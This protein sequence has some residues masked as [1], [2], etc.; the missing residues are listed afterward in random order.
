MAITATD[1]ITAI[2]DTQ[3]TRARGRNLSAYTRDKAKATAAI[4]DDIATGRYRSK[5]CYKEKDI[6]NVNGKRRHI[7]CPD[8]YT[9]ILE[10]LATGLLS[11]IYAR[12][13]PMVGVNCKKGCGISAKWR[14][15]SVAKRVK[16]IFYDRRDMKYALIIDQRKCYDHITPAVFR[17]SL[18]HID[19][20]RWLIDFACDIAFVGKRFPIG[21]PV[22]PLAHHIVMLGH[23]L[24]IRRISPLAVRYADDN[25]IPCRTRE[26]A[27]AAKWRVKNYWW[28]VQG[29]RAKR[30]T[31]RVVP[32]SQPVDFCGIV[33]HR[34]EAEGVC[35][36]NK[37]YTLL[38]PDIAR[39]ALTRS[40]PRRWP[41]YFGQLKSVDG[42]N[43]MLKIQD[44]MPSLQRLTE[45]IR[46]NRRLDAPNITV[47]ELAERGLYFAIHDYEIR[48]DP[49][50]KT[51]WIKCLISYPSE[52][53]AGKREVREYHG[54]YS[55][56]I[57]FHLLLEQQVGRSAVMPITCARIV[58]ACGYIYE[59]S[60]N[61]ITEIPDQP[62][63][64]Q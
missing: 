48:C 24:L 11:P 18:K 46:I 17:R 60:T 20:P 10:H 32:L 40:T 39:R 49:K 30:H 63:Y 47:Q 59:D 62:E 9:L 61:M 21:T 29:I 25:L 38:R 31:A 37:G 52:E 53:H 27:N 8:D 58:N 15:G 35:S 23:D 7:L 41:S 12:L 43:M 64:N 16:H 33:Y 28:Y 36:H 4:L 26:E 45:K 57:D 14:R 22:S 34:N 2:T 19:A 44:K 51:N 13:D 3:R 50:N 54:N 6:I 5:L 42:Y 1:I 55:G 56:I